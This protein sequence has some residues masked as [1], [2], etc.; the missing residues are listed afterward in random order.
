MLFGGHVD[1]MRFEDENGKWIGLD[2][3]LRLREFWKI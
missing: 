2:D 3:K 1:Q